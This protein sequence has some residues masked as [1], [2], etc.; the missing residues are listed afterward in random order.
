MVP[1]VVHDLLQM[2][3]VEALAEDLPKIME[4]IS[5]LAEQDGKLRIFLIT[6]C[7]VRPKSELERM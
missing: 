5:K 7:N 6:S 4:I 3:P 1:R 2:A